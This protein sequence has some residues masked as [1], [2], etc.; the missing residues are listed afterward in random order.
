V[1]RLAG[2]P[3]RRAAARTDGP[4]P[5]VVFGHGYAVTPAIYADLPRAW[6]RAGFV[7]AAPVFPLENA[8]APSGPTENDLVNQPAAVRQT[9]FARLDHHLAV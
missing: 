1:N 7:V 2:R 3:R 5:L 6:T 9:P 8:A 4:F